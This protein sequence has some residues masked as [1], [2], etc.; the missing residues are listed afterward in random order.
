MGFLTGPAPA[1]RLHSNLPNADNLAMTTLLS[2]LY[3]ASAEKYIAPVLG[4]DATLSPV[5]P[6]HPGLGDARMHGHSVSLDRSVKQGP[7][8]S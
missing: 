5:T 6:F 3:C 7:C 1:G 4:D 2:V 8:S